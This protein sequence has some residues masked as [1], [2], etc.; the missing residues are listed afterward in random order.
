MQV[1]A[2]GQQDRYLSVDP[3]ITFWYQAYKHHTPFATVPV[4]FLFPTGLDF[5][6]TSIFTIPK[7]AGDMLGEVYL[8]ISLPDLGFPG[9]WVDTVGYA[10]LQRVQVFF[11]DTQV[12]DHDKWWYDVYDRLYVDHNSRTCLDAMV[13]RGV[14]LS[15]NQVN[16]LW[17]PLHL[18]FT[19][20]KH[21]SNLRLPLVAITNLE[22][23]LQITL[24]PLTRLVV[25]GTTVTASLADVTEPVLLLNVAFL[26][27]PE[28]QQLLATSDETMIEVSREQDT[29]NYR[30]DNTMDQMVTNLVTVD[31]GFMTNAVKQIVWFV[32]PEA[33]QDPSNPYFN[34][35]PVVTQGTLY[36]NNDERFA[37]RSGEYF[38]LVQPFDYCTAV[39]SRAP[40]YSYSFALNAGHRQPSGAVDMTAFINNFLK[41]TL[42]SNNT[43]MVI[44][45]YSFGYNVLTVSNG[46]ATLKFA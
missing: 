45:T 10:L 30:I 42:T 2:V 37:G 22:I 34:Y 14:N 21:P 18:F 15:T 5:G 1:A 39:S 23:K 20:E 26:D 17:V 13:G 43:P 24:E 33:P 29:M 32:L 6:Q 25:G 44:K 3:S 16:Q 8:E 7:S 12:H 11:G 28:Q 27:T 41:L 9:A 31:L 35:A 19:T 38:Q 46:L 36:F 4:S 40:I